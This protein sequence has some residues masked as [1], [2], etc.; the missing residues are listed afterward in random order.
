MLNCIII[1]DEELA[2]TLLNSYVDKLDFITSKGEF[3]N[4]LEALSL[5]K[6]EAIDVIFLD[7]QMPQL[8]GTDFAKMV[9]PTTRI[10]FT[11]AYSE[12]ALDGYEL[13]AVDYLLKPITF[14]RFLTAVNKVQIPIK[15]TPKSSPD[16]ITIKSGYDLH[17]VHL[18]DIC[19]IKSD[20]EYVTFY[21]E[22]TKIMSYQSLK[23]LEDSL[24]S[25]LFMRVHRSYIINKNKVQSLKD[26][27]VI[28]QGERIP[29]STTYFDTV[30]K[31]LFS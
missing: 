20:S 1:D 27:D 3:E 30:K 26:K 15:N 9:A 4:P 23:S 12:Y 31:E 14:E 18:S 10:I 7:I 8:K 28:I 13:N 16:T 11:T 6:S 17:K 25:T 29:V 19:Y 5:L 22:N 24:P 2:R 21:M